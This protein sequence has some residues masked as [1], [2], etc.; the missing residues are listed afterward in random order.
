MTLAALLSYSASA[1]CDRTG[2]PHTHQM[3]GEQGFFQIATGLIPALLFG[4]L[5]FNRAHLPDKSKPFR[6]VDGLAMVGIAALGFLSIVAVATAISGAIGGSV[7]PPGRLLVI[8]VILIGMVLIILNSIAPRMSHLIAQ[9]VSSSPIRRSALSIMAVL[10]A[11]SA[12]LSA[13]QIDGAIKFGNDSKRIQ[14]AKELSAEA[15]EM[16]RRIDKRGRRIRQ[17]NG[18]IT[19]YEFGPKPDSSVLAEIERIRIANLRTEGTMEVISA[20]QE[21]KYWVV[22]EGQIRR[23]L[24]ER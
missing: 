7:T 21:T 23:L 19:K 13:I 14:L 10:L 8:A 16:D 2:Y 3:T 1:T 20:Q 17:I 4:G 22:V 11:V 15:A 24:E 12:T 18:E 9:R 5:L 6:D